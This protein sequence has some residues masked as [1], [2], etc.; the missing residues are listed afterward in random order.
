[1]D[2]GVYAKDAY[3]NMS[4]RNT[5]AVF[6]QYSKYEHSRNGHEMF[7][8]WIGAVGVACFTA[9]FLHLCIS[10][11]NAAV[12]IFRNIPAKPRNAITGFLNALRPIPALRHVA[13][14]IYYLYR[15]LYLDVM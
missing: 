14:C 10:Y 9:Y 2:A 11:S 1:M 15:T 13:D 12:Y 5:S 3:R 7:S 8:T 6:A 4:L